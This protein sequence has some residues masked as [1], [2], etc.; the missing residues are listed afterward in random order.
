[1]ATRTLPENS[2]F[3]T[4]IKLEQKVA[5]CAALGKCFYVTNL[6]LFSFGFYFSL[7]ALSRTN[8]F[9]FEP[10][11]PRGIRF[12]CKIADEFE[13]NLIDD[14]VHTVKVERL[15]R[16]ARYSRLQNR[17]YVFLIEVNV[18]TDHLRHFWLTSERAAIKQ[19]VAA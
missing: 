8:P 7:C 12:S 1:M 18:S 4:P 15:P 13:N 19:T 2:C 5:L 6:R 16:E 17:L 10:K 3:P 9:D 11:P 14:R